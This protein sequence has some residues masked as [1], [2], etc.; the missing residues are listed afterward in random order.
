MRRADLKL[1]EFCVVF[2]T[3]LLGLLALQILRSS[4]VRVAC[5]DIN[6]ERLLKAKQLGAEITI[7]ANNEDAVLAIND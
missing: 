3:G 4:G 6:D 2:G 5:I 7:N 1:G